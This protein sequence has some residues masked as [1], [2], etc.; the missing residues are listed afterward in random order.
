VS[1]CAS[2]RHWHQQRDI[3]T[4]EPIPAGN[5]AQIVKL[6]EDSPAVVPPRSLAHYTPSMIGFIHTAPDFGCVRFEPKDE[7]WL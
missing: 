1:Y 4:L 6:E 2:C 7:V 5:C 3:K